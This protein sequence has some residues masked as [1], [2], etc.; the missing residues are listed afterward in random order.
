MRIQRVPQKSRNSGS[1][2]D[3]GSYQLLRTSYDQ[4]TSA[5]Y[6]HRNDDSDYGDLLRLA[7]RLRFCVHRDVQTAIQKRMFLKQYPITQWEV[8]LTSDPFP[9]SDVSLK[10]EI[11]RL[12]GYL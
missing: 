4:S 2:F 9:Y 6:E 3:V 5:L 11:L 8:K 10:L 12:M 7:T 1:D